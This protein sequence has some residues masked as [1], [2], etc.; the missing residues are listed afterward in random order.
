VPFPSPFLSL[1]S[2]ADAS[3]VG[4]LPGEFPP[5]DEVGGLNSSN[6]GKGDAGQL[7]R[8]G[9]DGDPIEGGLVGIEGKKRRG[10]VRFGSRTL[11]KENHPPRGDLE[12]LDADPFL[13]KAT[14]MVGREVHEERAPLP[15]SERKANLTGIR[16]QME[17]LRVGA[18][19]ETADVW[20]SWMETSPDPASVTSGE[21]AGDVGGHDAMLASDVVEQCPIPGEARERTSGGLARVNGVPKS[22]VCQETVV[23]HQGLE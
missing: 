13:A 21:R 9:S 1:Q 15:V 8:V 19:E 14:L 22:L 6:F 7:R 4:L 2:T 20:D 18:K 17:G 23:R 12:L 16:V 5:P 3:V 10:L 11:Q